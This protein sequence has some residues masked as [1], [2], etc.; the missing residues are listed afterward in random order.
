MKKIPLCIPAT[1]EEE[2]RAVSEI[3]ASGWLAHGPKNHEFEEIFAKFV[4]V[5]HAITMNSCT[6]ALH[7][8][9][10]GL[11]ITGEVIVPSFTWVASVN[12]ILLAGG[13][14][15]MVDID[16]DT[17]NISFA[18]I[19]EA[20][21]AHTEA[22]MV[23]HYGGLPADMPRIIELAKRHKLRII[24]DSAEC[25]GGTYA[26]GTQAG[27][28]DIGCFSFF[29]TK[30]ITTG[31]GG[32]F[33]TNDDVL[34]KNIRSL[35]AHGI[36][37]STYQRE[38]E[39][40]PWLRRASRAGYNFRMSN[41]LAAIGVEQMRKLD[42]F[43]DARQRIARRYIERLQGSRSVECQRVAAG[44]V[45]SWQM[46]TVLV[47]PDL[48]DE[49]IHTLR[50]M[51]IGASVHFDPPVHVQSPY[52]GV[53]RG[54]SLANTEEVASRLVTLPIFPA[55][56]LED[57]DYITQAITGFFARRQLSAS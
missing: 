21:T 27:S 46:F 12:S 26:G 14:P 53:R 47:P 28:Y 8:A 4:G 15:V 5:K 13:T 52:V 20:I 50:E 57:V 56:P 3:L 51:G 54:S 25:L 49:L 34:A 24:E 43:N 23:V 16:V 11:G 32:M 42:Q 41:L 39:K 29:P 48:R 10:E 40:T 38:L 44:F 9:V 45:S 31:E 22:I 36:D 33:T 35:A 17:R 19:E 2:I 6:S 1:G 30:N 55:M 37:S 18:A 7:L